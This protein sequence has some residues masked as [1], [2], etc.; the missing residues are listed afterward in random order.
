MRSAFHEDFAPSTDGCD[1]LRSSRIRDG[2]GRKWFR[3][4]LR[5]S[6]IADE[7]A[8][9]ASRLG[10]PGKGDESGT[11]LLQVLVLHSRKRR[12]RDLPTAEGRSHNARQLVQ[13]L[14]PGGLMGPRALG[15]P[16][17]EG[18]TTWQRHPIWLSWRCRPYPVGPASRGWIDLFG[19]AL[20]V[21]PASLTTPRA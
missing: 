4:L 11:D 21:P 18:A 16:S 10:F 1:R 3:P 5:S 8:Q 14:G 7:P 2:K 12:L 19:D 17:V 20:S 15:E 9:H 6:R 13:F